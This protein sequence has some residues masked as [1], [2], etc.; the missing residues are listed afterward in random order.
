MCCGLSRHLAPACP[1]HNIFITEDVRAIS[2]TNL[3]PAIPCRDKTFNGD[4]CIPDTPLP[5]I[6]LHSD[7]ENEESSEIQMESD[8]DTNLKPTSQEISEDTPKP[9]KT[10]YKTKEKNAKKTTKTNTKPIR[11]RYLLKIIYHLWQLSNLKSS[12]GTLCQQSIPLCITI[13]SKI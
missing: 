10:P 9:Q 2:H 11:M 6:L 8:V 5:S 3:N 7:N 4:I 13:T 12:K 1:L